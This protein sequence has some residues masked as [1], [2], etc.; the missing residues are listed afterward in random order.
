MILLHFL[1]ILRSYIFIINGNKVKKNNEITCFLKENNLFSTNVTN[2]R[3]DSLK[4]SQNICS[5]LKNN[6]FKK[7]ENY[8]KKKRN[9]QIHT[10]N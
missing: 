7:I 10:K 3:V 1:F 9:S 6:N 8:L 2:E 5:F 4:K